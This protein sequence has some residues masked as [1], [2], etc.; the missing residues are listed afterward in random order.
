MSNQETQI[1]EEI[2]AKIKGAWTAGL[3]CMGITLLFIGLGMFI[4]EL[5]K[6]VDAWALIDVSIL[7]VLTYGVYKR[8][9]ASSVGLFLFYL[10]E[11]L[12]M[13]SQTGKPNGI[14]LAIV[15][16]YLFGRGVQGTFEYHNWKKEMQA[17]DPHYS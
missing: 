2:N 12:F 17:T 3:V 8:S 4:P 16:F 7:G 9:R 10:L 6:I 5:G 13:W 1:P 14:V 15:F 11:K